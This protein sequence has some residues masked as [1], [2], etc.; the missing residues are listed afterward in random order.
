M[1]SIRI[2]EK[3]PSTKEKNEAHTLFS[4]FIFIQN[5]L[6]MKPKETPISMLSKLK[7]GI[8]KN[9]FSPIKL[10]YMENILNSMISKDYG[11]FS[12]PGRHSQNLIESI[13]YK[14]R[15]PNGTKRNLKGKCVKH[16]H[17]NIKPCPPG[18]IRHPDTGRCRKIQTN[19]KNITVCPIGCIVDPNL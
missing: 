7:T 3:K 18:K 13:I 15:C 16:T 9:K 1:K 6:D 8:F 4:T 11:I 2:G 17:K 10:N 5:Y 12:E 14:K 19:K